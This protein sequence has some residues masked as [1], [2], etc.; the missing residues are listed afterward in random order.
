M[1][2]QLTPETALCYP[3]CEKPGVTLTFQ[4][5]APTLQKAL[6]ALREGCEE[7]HLTERVEFDELALLYY[8]LEELKKH[9]FL[10]YS[11]PFL[12]MLPLN[13]DFALKHFEDIPHQ[14]SRFTLCRPHEGKFIVENPLGSA[15]GYLSKEGT[16]LFYALS[17]PKRLEEL[18]LDFPEHSLDDIRDTL[19]LLKAGKMIVSLEEESVPL[20][21]WEFHD[22]Y[23]H[24]RSRRGRID[25]GYGG[26][27]RFKGVLP[28]QP[29]IKLCGNPSFIP[30]DRP[31]K[32]ARTFFRS[33][34]RKTEIDP[35]AG[36]RSDHSKTVGRVFVALCAC[37][38][39]QTHAR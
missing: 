1:K 34:S 23:F 32:R 17:V 2:I 7:Q 30:L 19:S 36:A 29:P 38:R 20:T 25:S 22:L 15:R 14:L 10:R 11:T 37:E 31:E 5:S 16:Q 3:T 8:Y 39:P 26:T 9:A 12:D 13:G 27:F 33:H 28:S 4:N 6:E 24:T 18:A 21:Q 35:R